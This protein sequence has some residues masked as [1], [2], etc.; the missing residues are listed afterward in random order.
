MYIAY[1][2]EPTILMKEIKNV[3]GTERHIVFIAW[4][5]PT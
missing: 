5:T 2:L 4:E 1:N 3:L